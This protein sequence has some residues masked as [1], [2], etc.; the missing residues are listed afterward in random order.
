[1]KAATTTMASSPSRSFRDLLRSEEVRRC[2]GVGG[3]CLLRLQ[4]HRQHFT[5]DLLES[6]AGISPIKFFCEPRAIPQQQRCC[7]TNPPL[8]LIAAI[9]PACSPFLIHLSRLAY[10]HTQNH[11]FI[12]PIGCKRAYHEVPGKL[13]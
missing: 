2:G 7:I 6:Q 1:M 3:C 12:P 8:C 13:T 5:K 10:T 11:M 4:G 9:L